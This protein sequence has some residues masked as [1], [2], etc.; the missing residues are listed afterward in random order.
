MFNHRFILLVRSVN[1]V[2][3]LKSTACFNSEEIMETSLDLTS[4]FPTV[5]DLK[6]RKNIKT[7]PV[8]HI[9]VQTS[10]NT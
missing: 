4:P 5:S 9:N 7:Q 1:L 6:H 2:K 10:K 3:T 8:D